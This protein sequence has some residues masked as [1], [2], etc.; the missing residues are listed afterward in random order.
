[1]KAPALNAKEGLVAI[2]ECQLA[3]STFA[4]ELA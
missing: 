2:E 4:V 1:L 3:Y